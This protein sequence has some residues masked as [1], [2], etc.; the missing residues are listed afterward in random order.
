MRI[1]KL[2]TTIAGQ[3]LTDISGLTDRRHRQLADAGHFP[4]PNRGAYQTGETLR[5]LF[6]YYKT[7]VAA[8]ADGL[9]AAR[10]AKLNVE[11][12]LL[13]L[14]R[15]KKSG[16]LISCDDLRQENSNIAIAV[17]RVITASALSR[18]DQNKILAELKALGSVGNGDD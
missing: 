13:C 8:R 14:E 7:T 3:Q 16:N 18:K 15:D 6:K 5:G 12:E 4:P 17:R 11:T 10:L 2:P 1:T 9:D